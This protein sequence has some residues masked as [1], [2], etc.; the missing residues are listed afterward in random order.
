VPLHPR[1][2]VVDDVDSL[3]DV[4]REA[5]GHAGFEV[6]TAAT[7]TEALD[8]LAIRHYA[9]IIADCVLPGLP[10][11]DWLATLRGAALSTPLILCSGTIGDELTRYAADFQAAVLQ[12][13]FSVGQLVAAVRAAMETG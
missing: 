9:V 3:R 1:V 12:K 13:P 11:L 4:F 8:R 2:L 7:A 10:V 5:L 6:D